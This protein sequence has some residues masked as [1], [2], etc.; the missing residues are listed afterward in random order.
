MQNL[1]KLFQ[2]MREFFDNYNYFTKKSGKRPKQTT[3]NEIIA[4]DTN[5]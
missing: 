2:T 1:F 5:K 4:I 3:N